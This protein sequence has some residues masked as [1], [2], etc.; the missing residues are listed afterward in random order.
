M[1]GRNVRPVESADA[2]AEDPHTPVAATYQE[3]A[4]A[5]ARQLAVTFRTVHPP[6]TGWSSA[7][8]WN[9]CGASSPAAPGR[10]GHRGTGQP[11]WSLRRLTDVAYERS[12]EP[13]WI[14]VV[15]SQDRPG[16]ATVRITRTKAGVEQDVTLAFG[17]GPDEEVPVDAL[18]GPRR[19]SPPATTSSRCS[20][21]SAEPAATWRCRRTSRVR[22][23]R[24]PS[25][26]ARRRSAKCPATAPGKHRCP[27]R[28]FSWVPGLVPRCTTPFRA[29]RRTWRAG[30]TSSGS[31]GI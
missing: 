13:T 21:S 14:V 16:L 9:R 26:W 6:T 3:V 23:S 22:A 7:A 5:G 25:C 28:P 31:Y 12:P 10:L 20:Y 8:P 18:P 24:W 11:P 29:T 4:N 1:A 17:Y 2:T 15:G 27:S 30:G 19:C